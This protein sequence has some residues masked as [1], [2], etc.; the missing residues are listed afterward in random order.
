MRIKFAE[1][2]GQTC[3]TLIKKLNKKRSVEDS[4][5]VRD[6]KDEIEELLSDIKTQAYKAERK[7]NKI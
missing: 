2:I 5:F 1:N 7:I 4:D 6:M 3:D